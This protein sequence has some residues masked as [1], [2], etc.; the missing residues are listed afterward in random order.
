M[1]RIRYRNTLFRVALVAAVSVTFYVAF[2][3]TEPSVIE[4]LNDKLKHIGAFVVLSFLTDFAFPR[5]P[6]ELR[7]MAALLLLGV[8][9]EVVQYFLPYREASGLDVLADVAGIAGYVLARPL[10]Q[11]FPWLQYRWQS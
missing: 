9:I 7:K 10:L 5:S 8:F 11:R 4:N 3:Q 2:S 1:D 6:F